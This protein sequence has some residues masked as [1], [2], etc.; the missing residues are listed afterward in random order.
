MYRSS[1][2]QRGFLPSTFFFSLIF[3]HHIGPQMWQ[4]KVAR[5]KKCRVQ[6]APSETS[7]SAAPADDFSF[8]C[9]WSKRISKIYTTQ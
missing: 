4:K 8:L 3:V 1:E 7:Y 9:F 6:L 2:K 5:G